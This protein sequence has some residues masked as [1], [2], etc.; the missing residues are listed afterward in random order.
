QLRYAVDIFG[1]HLASVDLRQNSDVHETVVAEL[2]AKAAVCADYLQL[3]EA[4]RVSLLLRELANPRSLRIAGEG[5]SEVTV[6][7]LNVFQA[8]A[9]I[10][11]RFG[12]DAVPNAIISKAQSVSDLP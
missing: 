9:N 8:A 5:Y 12:S 11:A 10:N 6:G 3:D 2:L 1:F 7:E 4:A